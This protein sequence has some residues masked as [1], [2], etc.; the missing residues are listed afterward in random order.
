MHILST[1]TDNCP[2][3]ISRRERMTIENISWSISIK[4]C[5]Q[6][7]GGR[8]CNLLITSRMRSQV[9]K[10][11]FFFLCFYFELLQLRCCSLLLFVSQLFLSCLRKAVLHNYDLS[12]VTSFIF[13]YSM[14]YS[15]LSCNAVHTTV[16]LGASPHY[17]SNYKP[18]EE[19]NITM[20]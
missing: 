12:R 20:S 13:L 19:K 5:C 15:R 6:P 14:L 17:S 10:D 3:W 4:E 8:T 9:T 1:E 16:G 7:G 2:S 11:G 18:Q